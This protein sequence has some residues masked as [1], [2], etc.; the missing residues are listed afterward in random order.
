MRR[1]LPG[2]S[3]PPVVPLAAVARDYS[4]AMSAAAAPAPLTAV[5][6]GASS[7]IGRATA[8]RLAADGWRVLA[9]A[10]RED[11]LASLAAETGCL[12][13]AVDVTSDSSVAGLVDR[14]DELF[15][16]SLNAVVNIAGG[17]LG[18]ERIEDADIEQWRAMYETNVLGTLRVTRA[19]LP[20]LRASGRG[21]VLVLSST[22]ADAAYEGGG[23]YN[24]AKAGERMIAGAL[25]L[26][27]NGERIRVIEIAPGMV[28]TEEFSLVR[29]GGDRAAADRV[30]DGVEQPLTA[31]DC[32]DVIAYALGAP[33]HVNLDL[34]T[35]RPLAQAAQH[36]V[37]RGAGL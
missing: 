23:G 29:L 3:A 12:T 15:G 11:R 24:A 34:V 25:R 18:T 36:K 1:A 20:A 6:T 33:H 22:A 4:G 13:H 8:R 30:Y 7:G 10:R 37:A 31:E 21:D 5:V 32:A 19:L 26:E 9:V 17:A 2:P 16:G 27:L 35:V 14:V 28:R